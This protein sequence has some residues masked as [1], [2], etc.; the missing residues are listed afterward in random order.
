MVRISSTHDLG[1]MLMQD[2]QD[3]W[4]SGHVQL[5]GQDQV[6]GPRVRLQR[7]LNRPAQVFSLGIQR[8][9]SNV[10][11]ESSGGCRHLGQRGNGQVLG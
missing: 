3:L 11:L 10:S 6:L 2:G 9:G 7:Q 5:H 1:I 4:T 8:P